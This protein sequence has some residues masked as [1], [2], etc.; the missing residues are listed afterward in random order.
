MP[1]C[2]NSVEPLAASIGELLTFLKV[3]NANGLRHRVAQL[4]L[5]KMLDV[6]MNVR[7]LEPGFGDELRWCKIWGV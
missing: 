1:K 3:E 5:E 4:G 7:C 6:V 2:P